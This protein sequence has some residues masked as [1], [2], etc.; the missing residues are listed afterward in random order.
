[1]AAVKTSDY[2][3]Y[4]GEKRQLVGVQG[5]YITPEGVIYS[6]NRTSD[7]S[8]ARIKVAPGGFVRLAV[9][10]GRY[11]RFR[12]KDFLTTYYPDAVDDYEKRLQEG[13]QA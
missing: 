2:V 9:G 13:E 5:Y 10:G 6:A 11:K 4:T 3:M 12:V 8:L 1:M 7:G